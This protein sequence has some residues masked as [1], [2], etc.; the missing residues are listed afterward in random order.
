MIELDHIVIGTRSLEE[1]VKNLEDLLG[2][3]LAPG[4]QHLGFGTHNRLV[5]LGPDCYLE[6]IALDP[7]QPAAN[8]ANAP[9]FGLGQPD[10]QTA[11][12]SGP[13]LQLLAWAA[14]TASLHDWPNLEPALAPLSDQLIE[15]N[16][17]TWLTQSI[18]EPIQMS[19]GELRWTFVHRRDGHPVPDGLPSILSWGSTPHPC[20]RLSDHGLRIQNLILRPSDK[21]RVSTSEWV[22]TYC[23]DS[24]IG[25]NVGPRTATDNRSSGIDRLVIQTLHGRNVELRSYF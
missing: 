17:M 15:S 3:P 24:R 16:K 18:G 1:G 2:C 22:Q 4:G 23:Q 9:L 5:S 21:T 20:S 12:K 8:L 7:K 10:M 25:F 11:L 13:A 6:L 14:R 19:R